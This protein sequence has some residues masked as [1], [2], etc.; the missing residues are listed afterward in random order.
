MK[1]LPYLCALILIPVMSFAEDYH[2][3]KQAGN[4]RSARVV[5]HIPVSDETNAVGYSLRIALSEYIGGDAFVS[6]VPWLAGQELTDIRN[7]LIFE[8]GKTVSFMAA[9][10]PTQKLAKVV[11]KFNSL[12]VKVIDKIKIELKFWHKEATQ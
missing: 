7:G 9:D 1:I 4:G 11:D 3:L 12:S 8:R 6:E 2:V 5:F 10:S